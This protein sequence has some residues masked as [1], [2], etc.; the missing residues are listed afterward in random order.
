M[1]NFNENHH[2]RGSALTTIMLLIVFVAFGAVAYV[3]GQ[4][5]VLQQF[6][7]QFQQSQLASAVGMAKKADE[8]KPAADPV[9]NPVVARVNGEEITRSE[10]LAMVQKMPPQMQQIPMEQLLPLSV[11]QLITNVIIDEKAAKANLANDPD[12]KEQL[13]TVREQLVRTKYVENAVDERLT[14]ERLKEAY[15][16]YVENFPET[17]EVKAAH[18]LVQEEAVAKDAIAKLKGGADFAALAKELSKDGT[19]ANGGDLGFFAAQEVVPEFAEATFGAEPGLIEAPVKSQFGYHV[20]RVDEKRIRPVEAYEDVKPFLEQEM[21]RQVF[22]ETLQEWKEAADIER[23]D[24]NG[25]P[26]GQQEPAAGAEEA[27]DASEDAEAA[28]EG[29]SADAE[30]APE[31]EAAESE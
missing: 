19:A 30:A 31:E 18:I 10:V 21:Q 17:E 27:E 9:N 24:I 1:H 12:V 13:A 11:E 25:N 23:F 4:K 8:D 14:D 20:I 15:Q 6:Q 22:E 2:E 29:A 26:L 16:E 3:S 7:T 5:N 28:D